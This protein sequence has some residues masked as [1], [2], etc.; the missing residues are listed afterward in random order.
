M[1]TVTFYSF[2]GGVGRSM[3]LANAA[4]E[5][6]MRGKR[7]LVV[8]FDLEAPGLHTFGFCPGEPMAGGVVDFVSQYLESNESPNVKNHIIKCELDKQCDGE[9]FLMPAGAL[10]ENYSS[11]LSK[12]D[13]FDLYENRSGYLLIE[14]LKAQ[15]LQEINPDYVLIDSR[16]GHSD[17]SGICTRQLPNAVVFLFFPNEQNLFGLKNIVS[18]VDAENLS[19]TDISSKIEKHFVN[20]NV[21]DLDDENRILSDRLDNF[22]KF[23][24][25]KDL[26]ATIH[27]YDSLALLNQDIFTLNRPHT[28]LAQEY[29]Q[30]VEKIVFNNIEDRDGAVAFLKD[31]LNSKRNLKEGGDTDVSTENKLEKIAN[32]HEKDAEVLYIYSLVKERHGD[33]EYALALMELVEEVGG[34]KEIPLLRKARLLISSARLDEAVVEIRRVLSIADVGY[35]EVR[36]AINFLNRI[37]R[38]EVDRAIFSSAALSL[39]PEGFLWILS[40][41]YMGSVSELVVAEKAT[42]RY[43]ENNSRL[44][45]VGYALLKSNL[46]LIE[47]GLG[48]FKEACVL[49]SKTRPT[50]VSTL[51]KLFNYA[52][53]EWGLN[54]VVP[55]DLIDLS[56]QKLSTIDFS[57]ATPNVKQC[58]SLCYWVRGDKEKAEEILD[59]ARREVGISSQLNFSCWSYT[60]LDKKG[61]IDDLNKMSK[62]FEGDDIVP[63]YIST[64]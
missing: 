62:L 39:E 29:R 15:W 41:H 22:A 31:T 37:D 11:R 23:L 30:L 64:K 7:V 48:K 55:S 16:T 34:Y 8:D 36:L 38:A 47:I 42:Y 18:Q 54:G 44:E 57:K 13:W 25:Y 20:S 33:F 28:R 32:R 10:D 60:Y 59:I 24:K 21:P 4:A 12:I 2:K 9:L 6:A 56:L 17:V 53:A 49:I 50:K 19:R 5:L 61:F 51:E 26:T 63:K 46:A 3:A 52:M 35:S 1:Y 40:N 14:D 45:S 58:I 43:F 27:R